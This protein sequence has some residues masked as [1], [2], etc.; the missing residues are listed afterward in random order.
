MVVYQPTEGYCY[1]SDTIFLY[2]F[3]S[4]LP[5][6]GNVLDVGSGSGILALLT[7]RDFDANVSAVELQEEFVRYAKINAQANRLDIRIYMGDFLH[8]LFDRKFD[9][10]LSNPP[11][12]HKDVLRARNKMV[13][14][15]RYSGYLPPEELIGKVG[16]I[17]KPK[18]SFVF[19]YDAKQVSHILFLLKERKFNVERMRFVHPRATRSAS[20]VMIHAKK[21]SKSLCETLPPLVV[22]EG[23]HYSQEAK[24]IFKRVG[25]HSIKCKI[26]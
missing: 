2:D 8:M 6:K 11:F 4:K 1:N 10:V 7:K 24:E 5:V 22:F 12:Y 17:L 13:D 23:E 19:C 18:G 21:G 3:F 25:V 15:A 9:F 20:L 16:S 26:S 14:M